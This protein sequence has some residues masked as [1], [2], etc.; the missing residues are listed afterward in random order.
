MKSPSEGKGGKVKANL[1]ANVQS[2]QLVGGNDGKSPITPG[3][4]STISE[5]FFDGGKTGL[6]RG[7][8]GGKCEAKYPVIPVS[9]SQ[10]TLF[11]L[12]INCFIKRVY[13]ECG[14]FSG[15]YRNFGI[16]ASIP[17]LRLRKAPI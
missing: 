10:W 4:K 13:K 15:W 16:I 5:L 6:H 3:N 17:P 8:L 1:K 12:S 9:R 7:Q 11:S 14:G 2:L